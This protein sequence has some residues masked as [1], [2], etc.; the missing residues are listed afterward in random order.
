MR[1]LF[2]GWSCWNVNLAYLILVLTDKYEC[3]Y[4]C[5]PPFVFVLW[6]SKKQ[7]QLYVSRDSSDGS[8]WR[9]MDRGSTPRTDRSVFRAKCPPR[10]CATP[11]LRFYGHLEFFL[12]S[13][14]RPKAGV[15]T[16]VHLQPGLRNSGVILTLPHAPSVFFILMIRWVIV[17]RSTKYYLGGQTEFNEKRRFYTT[18]ENTK[19]ACRILLRKLRDN[20]IDL[21]VDMSMWPQS[22]GILVE[23]LHIEVWRTVE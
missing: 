1:Y 18:H 2:W 7:I 11:S 16:E 19:N 5:I 12:T 14:T 21:D 13:V 3:I 10:H 15:T 9:P 6:W 4:T 22:S 23:F 17:F 20:F 8:D